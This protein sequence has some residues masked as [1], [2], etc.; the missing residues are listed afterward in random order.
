MP[1]QLDL[2]QGGTYRE[3]D[4]VY[5]G[6]TVGW[7]WYPSRSQL[8]ISAAGTYV[9][10]PSTTYVQ[11]SIAGAVT[12]F[13]P[14]LSGITAPPLVLPGRAVK[15]PISIV[16][17]GGFAAANPI[18]I[19]PNS[20]ADTILGLTSIQIASAYGGFNLFPNVGTWTN[21]E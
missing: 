21:Q 16:D 10:D 18:T 9:L 3:W 17:V 8:L 12:I 19:M 4:K 7:V 13:L 2:D 6:P 14:P 5:L 20:I 11:V 1:S 15:A